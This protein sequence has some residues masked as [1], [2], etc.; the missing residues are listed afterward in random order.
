MIT[1]DGVYRSPYYIYEEDLKKPDWTL[2][3]DTATVNGY[4]CRKATCSHGGRDYEAW[5][6]PEIPVSEG[7]WKFYGL[8]GLILKVY[9]TN[10]FFTFECTSFNTE[11][12]ETDIYIDR[13][14]VVK[15]TK[16]KFDKLR[17]AYNADPLGYMLSASNGSVTIKGD[18]PS[19][20]PMLAIEL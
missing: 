11:E 8:P 13:K 9:D 1:I 12:R 7:P 19:R 17:K 16:A 6:S 2:S 15:T 10:H 20:P 14:D 5:Y 3:S 18:V 4:L